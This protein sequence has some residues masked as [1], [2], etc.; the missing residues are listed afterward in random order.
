MLVFYAR[1]KRPFKNAL[2]GMASGA[3]SLGAVKLLS[4]AIGFA[5]SINLFTS[6][7]ALICGIPG[8]I[9]M[10]VLNFLL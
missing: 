8:V 1:T 4:M 9:T 3:L 2:V 5:F 7:V 6:F 10:A